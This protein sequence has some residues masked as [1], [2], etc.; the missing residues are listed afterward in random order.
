M[1]VTVLRSTETPERLVCRAGRGDYFD[2]FVG[3]TDYPKL[4]E[5]VNYDEEHLKEE[6]AREGINWSDHN[7]HE[8]DDD[9]PAVVRAKTQSFIE[10]QLSRGHYGLWEHPQITIAIKGVSRATMAQI[11]RHRHMSFDVQSQRYVDFS[12]KEAITPR[13]MTDPDHFTRGE[14]E[15]EFDNI[16]QETIRKMYDGFTHRAMNWYQILVDEG[17][18]KEDARFLLPIGTPVNITMSGNARTMMHVLNLRQKA[19][20]QWEIREVSNK[21]ADELEEWMPYTGSWWRDNGPMKISP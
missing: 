12:G 13:S 6:L 5:S 2:G 11:T 7:P 3:D 9:N 1:E 21:V 14:G 16:E 8:F 10:K 17:V 19:D 4:M 18:P 15:I 20:S